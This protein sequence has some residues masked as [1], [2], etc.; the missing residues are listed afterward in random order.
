MMLRAFLLV[1]AVFAVVSSATAE[2]AMSQND[3]LSKGDDPRLDKSVT[4]D[5]DGITL[6]EALAKLSAETGVVMSAGQDENDWMVQD[7]KVIVHVRDMALRDLMR[8]IASIL[9]FQWSPAGDKGAFTYRIGQ[10]KLQRDEE[11]S[12]RAAAEDAQTTQAREKREN[13]LSDMVNLASLSQ[14]DAGKLKASDP[15]RYVLATQPLGRDVAEFVNSFPEGR[16]AFIQG[17]EVSFPVAALSPAQQSAVRR[18]A[19]S[20]DSLTRSIGISE[21][22]SALLSR[23]DKLQVTINRPMRGAADDILSRSL[24]G[25]ITIGLGTDALDIP[26]FDPG[27]MVGKALGAAIVRLQSGE[28]KDHVAKDLQ[29]AM[30]DAV[31]AGVLPAESG[32]DISSDPAL[33]VSIKLFDVPV[34]APLPM[35]LQSLTLNAKMNII[36]DYFVGAPPTVAGG[37]KPLGEQLEAIRMAYSV[38]WE[39]A[40]KTL[41]FRDREWFRKRAWEVSQRWI[42]Y[43]V[44]RAKQ[45]GGLVLDDLVQIGNLRDEQLDHTVTC[46]ADLIKYGAGE[47]VRNRQ[48]L[49]FYASLTADQLKSMLDGNLTASALNDAQWAALRSALATKGAAYAA[50]QKGSQVLQLTQSTKDVVEYTFTYYP[51]GGEPAVAFKLSSGVVYGPTTELN[52]P[53]KPGK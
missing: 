15:W 27:S 2:V 42:D 20:Y 12:L 3:V 22:H 5:V 38:N 13:A 9:R 14:A 51:G 39:K 43:W 10:D 8:E 49:R 11:N 6:S 34:V 40:G 4:F 50:A 52:L 26:L 17:T 7:R 29:A 47:A 18:I 23:F 53:D 30:E 25:R 33:K 41:R 28:S 44:A 35:T 48:I 21:D 32:R 31:K 36:S 16:N 24:L 19:E 1:V 45:N 37:A 46:N